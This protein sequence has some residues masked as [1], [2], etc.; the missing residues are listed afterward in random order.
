MDFTYSTYLFVVFAQEN[1]TCAR[2]LL[3]S[4]CHPYFA[5]LPAS[6]L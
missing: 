3:A 5:S 1:V 2:Y 6:S 4:F